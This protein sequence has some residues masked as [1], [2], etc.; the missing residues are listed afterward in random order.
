[1]TATE[2]IGFDAGRA[3][4]GTP[5][6]CDGCSNVTETPPPTVD[7]PPPVIENPPADSVATTT[8]PIVPE[9]DVASSTEMATTST[10]PVLEPPDPVII[11]VP[12]GDTSAT[13]ATLT[14]E[15]DVA[16]TTSEVVTST[17]Q[18][19]PSP[20]LEPAPTTQMEASQAASPP[21]YDLLRLNEV[22]PQPDGEAEWIEITSLDPTI[23][24]PLA[25]VELHDAVGK[26]HTFATGTVDAATPFVRVV[27]S[28]SRLNNDGDTVSITSSD[29][30]A[31]DSLTY[32]GSEKGHPWARE[33]DATG[34]WKLTLTPTPGLANIITEEKDPPEATA[35]AETTAIQTTVTSIPIVPIVATVSLP[36]PAPSP[37]TAVKTSTT[38]TVPAKTPAKQPSTKKAAPAATVASKTT[39][40]KTATAS[41]AKKVT[42]TSTVKKTT[43]T[44][45]TAAKSDE[46]I[47][48]TIAMTSSDT[49]RGIRVTLQGTVGSPSGLL[50]SHGFILLAPDGRGLLV[51]VPAAQ[52]LPAQDEAV[53]VTGTL[54][55]DDLDIPSLKLGTKDGWSVLPEKSPSPAPRNADLLAPGTEDRWSL[56]AA[57]GTVVRVQGTN[58]TISVDDAEIVVAIRKVVD[59]RASR[60][61]VGDTVR[62]IGLLDTSSASPR[63]HGT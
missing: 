42:T 9:T 2:S 63:I 8:D 13:D 23:S 20:A 11:D 55:F 19:V 4:L 34:S 32:D 28:S 56:V 43:T 60:L 47:P 36:E 22:M 50:S 35:A 49:Y 31:I 44:K 3:D 39:A 41:T 25:G 15:H 54:Q 29:G 12:T 37:V 53:R 26:I 59:Y 45:T 61:A 17:E 21:R 33:D 38:P 5:G 27:L 10:D 7:E 24:V 48:I 18:I 1:V 40:A 16:T 58:V 52:K 30:I 51:R 6:T 57:T 14:E 46:P 62:V